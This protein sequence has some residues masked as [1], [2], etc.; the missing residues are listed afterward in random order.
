MRRCP[1]ACI[2]GTGRIVGSWCRVRARGG[3]RLRS[4][5]LLGGPLVRRRLCLMRPCFLRVLHKAWHVV[6]VR[7]A[8]VSVE[9]AKERM[10]MSPTQRSTPE[11]RNHLPPLCFPALHT[12]TH[13]HTH[14]IHHQEGCAGT[15]PV[16]S[17]LDKAARIQGVSHQM[18]ESSGPPCTPGTFSS[19]LR[20]RRFPTS[21]WRQEPG[22][23]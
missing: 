20:A 8:S 21:R 9:C 7:E 10:H 5:G 11:G 3:R 15:T 13:T 2:W 18:R 17:T 4:V 22:L 23:G 1:C 12:H 16:V 14:R 6:G 19:G